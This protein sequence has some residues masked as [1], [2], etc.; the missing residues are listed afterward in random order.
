MDQN[1]LPISGIIL[2][3]GQGQRMKGQD[4]GWVNYQGRPLIEHLIERLAPQVDELI[5]NANRNLSAY[6]SYGYAVIEDQ[7]GGFQGPLMGILTGLTAATQPWVLFAPCDG[8]FLPQDLANKLYQAAQQSDQPIAVASDGQ[9]L[10]PVVVLIKK[11]CLD[12]LRAAMQEGERKPDR[13]YAS[14]GFVEVTFAPRSLQNF[15]R[16]EDLK[17]GDISII[18]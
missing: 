12:A 6:E 13:W 15:N 18:G 9:R 3:G 14:Q 8:P 1:K 2:A 16:P 11:N 5:I 17:D 7:A 4:K 10:Q